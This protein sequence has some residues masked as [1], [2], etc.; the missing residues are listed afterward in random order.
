VDLEQLQKA[1]AAA[2][3]L[4]QIADAVERAMPITRS[5]LVLR[6]MHD[7]DSVGEHSTYVEVGA[8]EFRIWLAELKR[9]R[10]TRLNELGVETK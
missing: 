7:R 3:D 6:F 5:T 4:K 2:A 1:S 9:K 10:E 8:G